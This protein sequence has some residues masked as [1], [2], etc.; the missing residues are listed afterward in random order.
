M[1]TRP[2]ATK[3]AVLIVSYGNPGDVDRCLKS[4]AQSDFENFHVFICENGGLEAYASLMEVIAHEQGALRRMEDCSDQLDRPGGRLECVAKCQFRSRSNLVRVALATDNLGYGGGVN[5]WLERLLGRPEWHAV[6]ILNPDTEVDETCLSHLV[7]KA[8]EGYGMVGGVLVFDGSPNK[9][10]NYGLR[11]SA[12]TGRVT[13]VGRH[14]PAGRRLTPEIIDKIDAISGACVLVTRDFIADVG[15]MTDDYFLYMED[16]DWG[17][18]RAHH[19]IGIAEGA[20]IR[21]VGGTTIG[22]AADPRDR[23]P[24]SV[25]LSARNGILYSRRRAGRRWVFHS[26]IWMLYALRYLLL[27]APA[28][29]MLTIEGLWHGINGRTGRPDISFDRDA[30]R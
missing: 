10:T 9:V 26:A 30:C 12:L 6:L 27:G 21:H 8:A 11:W 28:A 24:L 1:S 20:L 18:R 19:R 3:I 4:L 22:S 25:Y 13:A 17:R 29:A 14:S 2:E 23:S 15:L 5:A 7:G 16:L